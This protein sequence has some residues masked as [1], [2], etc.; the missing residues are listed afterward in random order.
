MDHP[1]RNK[2]QEPP[3]SGLDHPGTSGGLPARTGSFGADGL[4]AQELGPTG[5]TEAAPVI[6]V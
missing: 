5:C 6:R 1:E 4:S 3:S 2:Q